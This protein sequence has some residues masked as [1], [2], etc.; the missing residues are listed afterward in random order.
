MSEDDKGVEF[1]PDE[2][3]L[4]QIDFFIRAGLTMERVMDLS[5]TLARAGSQYGPP[6]RRVPRVGYKC[7]VCGTILLDCVETGSGGNV[8]PKSHARYAYNDEGK[9]VHVKGICP[10]SHEFAEW[11][12]VWEYTTGY[13]DGEIVGP[14]KYHKNRYKRNGEG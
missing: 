4:E 8:Y 13:K 7:S 6:R 11:V 9:Y 12:T 1:D 5:W 2:I 10:G 14:P 3:D